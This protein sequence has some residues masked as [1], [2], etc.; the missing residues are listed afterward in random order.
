MSPAAHPCA[1]STLVEPLILGPRRWARVV[2]VAGQAVYLLPYESELAHADGHPH[3]A[4]PT[5]PAGNP[6]SRPTPF[7][8]VAHTGVRVPAAVVLGAGAGERPFAALGSGT[9]ARIGGG[10]VEL[11]PLRLT[12]GVSWAPPRVQATPAAEALRVLAH[13]TP[14]R[15]L[16]PD[17]APLAA[18]LT[19]RARQDVSGSDRTLYDAAGALLGRGPGLTP[20][21]DDILCGLLLAANSTLPRPR[22]FPALLTATALAH[23]R[24][25]LVS[26]SLLTHA[27]AGHCIPE[28]AALLHAAASSGE[29]PTTHLAALLSV[30][31]TSGSDLLHGLCAGARLLHL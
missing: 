17:I 1:P 21:G 31:H 2:G 8:L 26:A 25:T 29:I 28:V 11:G 16:T 14:P 24:T 10:R 5:A 12:A 4:I 22:W 19:E 13:L 27:A 30:G 20:S 6:P 9:V 3:A 23:R 15:E 18:R 7:A